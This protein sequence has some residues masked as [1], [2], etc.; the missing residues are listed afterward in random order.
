MI[1]VRYESVEN[2]GTRGLVLARELSKKLETD[3]EGVDDY[4]EKSFCIQEGLKRISVSIIV[5]VND[6]EYPIIREFWFGMWND[7]ANT[8]LDGSLDLRDFKTS[9][10]L[11]K[12]NDFIE[13]HSF[14]IRKT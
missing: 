10:K 6:K 7:E 4:Y 13:L 11:I 14:L 8:F 3:W 5:T 1:F 9:L 2:F 12:E